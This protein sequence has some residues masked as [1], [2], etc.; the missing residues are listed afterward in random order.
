[1]SGEPVFSTFWDACAQ[2]VLALLTCASCGHRALLPR[3][4]CPRCLSEE[5]TWRL[6]TPRGVVDATTT[7]H[8]PASRDVAPGY[9][10]V[11]VRLV[12]GPA[13]L[14]RSEGARVAIEDQVAIGF[15]AADAQGRCVPVVRAAR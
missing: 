8:R 14:A 5:L 1:V 2:G 3:P 9:Q 7:V 10:L 4:A 11:L 6:A 15:A 13:L 12:D